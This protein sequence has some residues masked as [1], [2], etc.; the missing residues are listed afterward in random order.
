M[1]DFFSYPPIRS[2]KSPLC[3]FDDQSYSSDDQ[4]NKTFF[5]SILNSLKTEINI[6]Y[7]KTWAYNVI[8]HTS[9]FYY[10]SNCNPKRCQLVIILNCV[11]NHIASIKNSETRHSYNMRYTSFLDVFLSYLEK[12]CEW[13]EIVKEIEKIV[14]PETIANSFCF[15][16]IR[17]MNMFYNDTC[18]NGNS[19]TDS[20]GINF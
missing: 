15:N 4:V 3:S 8:N 1:S 11:K 2:T 18:T 5:S 9:D 19:F 12:N 7:V 17:M 13:A 16:D 10:P 6:D 14:Y 20:V